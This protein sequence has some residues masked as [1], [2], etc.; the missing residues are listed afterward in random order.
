MKTGQLIDAQLI[1]GY[2]THLMKLP[3]RFFDTM[4]I[5]EIISRI[6]DAIKIRNFIN[7]TAL[8]IVVNSLIILFTVTL[9]FTYYWKLALIISLIIPIY[10]AIYFTMNYLNKRNERKKKTKEEKD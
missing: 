9:M 5:G 4:R 1:L 8:E 2:Y 7:E 6:N 10:S 3:Q